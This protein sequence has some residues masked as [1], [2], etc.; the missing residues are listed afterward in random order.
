MMKG[1]PLYLSETYQFSSNAVLTICKAKIEK[2]MLSSM[3]PTASIDQLHPKKLPETLK[4][5]MSKA[6]VD[7]LNQIARYFTCNSVTRRWP[8]VI[9][10]L[11]L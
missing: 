9:F 10:F 11:T 6:G 5:Y 4:S 8:V 2:L 7:V 1:K 3:H